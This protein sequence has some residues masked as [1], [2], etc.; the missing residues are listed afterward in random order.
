[1]ASIEINVNAKA[2]EDLA[3][4]IERAKRMLLGR[5]AERGYQLLRAEAPART[6]NLRQGV[7]PPEVDYGSMQ[8]TLTVSA[9]SARIGPRQATVIGSDGKE[10]KQVT[11]K[12][13]EPYNYAEVVARGNRDAVLRPKTARAFLI[14]VATAPSDEGYLI[15][16]GQFFVVRR[17]RKAQQPNPYDERAAKRLEGEA[18]RIADV[19][20]RKIFV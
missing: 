7:A 19:V 18:D 16:G 9:R 13:V 10:K 15:S 2:A 11:L 3:K 5:M 14:P 17:S 20:L 6:G 4:D 1:M 12:A 8:A